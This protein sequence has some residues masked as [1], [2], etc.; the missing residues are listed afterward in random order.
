MNPIHD[1]LAVVA[2][3]SSWSLSCV[4]TLQ[5][6]R[7]LP[8]QA[9]H[10]EYG[11]QRFTGH[12]R[13]PWPARRILAPAHGLISQRQLL[14]ERIDGKQPVAAYQIYRVAGSALRLGL[15]RAHTPQ[16]APLTTVMNVHH[17]P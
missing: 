7:Q 6:L 2:A 15:W 8:A 4:V 11:A 17:Q 12:A 5:L 13:Q 1:S 14:A 10:V 3:M 16:I 9:N